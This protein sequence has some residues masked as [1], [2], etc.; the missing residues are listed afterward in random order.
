MACRT[1]CKTKDHESYAACMR[2]AG[3]RVAYCG[4]GGGDAT[5]QKKWDKEIDSYFDAVKQGIQPSGSRKHQIEKAVKIA[6]E[7]GTPAM[8]P[9]K[10]DA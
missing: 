5:T 7:T 9:P 6:N 4:Q 1:G 8:T 2:D 3:V 10:A